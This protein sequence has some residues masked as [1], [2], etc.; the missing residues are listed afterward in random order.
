M[1][2]LLIDSEML[3]PR[4]HTLSGAQLH[5]AAGRCLVRPQRS[6]LSK[7]LS[8]YAIAEVPETPQYALAKV[9]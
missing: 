2:L 4:N 7:Y 1:L 6:P 5:T 8:I 9:P 3:L